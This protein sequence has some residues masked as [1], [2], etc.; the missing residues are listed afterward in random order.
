[1]VVDVATA[2]QEESSALAQYVTLF[3]SRS[4]LW[5]S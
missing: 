3:P 4:E 1:M 2:E 5:L